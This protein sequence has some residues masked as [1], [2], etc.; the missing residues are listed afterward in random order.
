MNKES[1]SKH[2]G[3]IMSQLEKMVY[4]EIDIDTCHANARFIVT[5]C[6]NHYLLLEA[7]KT[8]SSIIQ[9]YVDKESLKIPDSAEV[10]SI[11]SLL[12]A[13]SQAEGGEV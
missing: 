5:A 1:G 6:N 4:G 2:D 3:R 10:R 7:L 13:L 12:S 11:K 8:A 9:Y